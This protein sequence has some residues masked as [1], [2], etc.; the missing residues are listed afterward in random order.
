[1][2]RLILLLHNKILNEFTRNL[3]YLNDRHCLF[4][5]FCVSKKC[6]HYNRIFDVRTN[7]FSIAH[8]IVLSLIYVFGAKKNVNKVHINGGRWPDLL[9]SGLDLQCDE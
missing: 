1:M 9:L 6:N 7:S 8:M 2:I 5:E 3:F 4:C